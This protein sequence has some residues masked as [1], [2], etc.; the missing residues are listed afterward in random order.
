MK[1]YFI[2]FFCLP[3]SK[4]VQCEYFLLIKFS[5]HFTFLKLNPLF[6][7]SKVTFSVNR[8]AMDVTQFEASLEELQSNDDKFMFISAEVERLYK[9]R[10]REH[11][12]AHSFLNHILQALLP[13][14]ATNL[15]QKVTKSIPN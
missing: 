2:Q 4:Y 6:K 11:K 10:H 1:C 8:V 3:N 9:D 13:L 14:V 15:E 7:S 12:I 5:N